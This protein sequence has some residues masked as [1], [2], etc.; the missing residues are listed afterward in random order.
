LG[1][2]YT[3]LDDKAIAKKMMDREWVA[4]AY[5]KAREKAAMFDEI[6]QTRGQ[7]ANQV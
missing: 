6:A 1:S 4:E 2:G 3:K 7:R 5:T